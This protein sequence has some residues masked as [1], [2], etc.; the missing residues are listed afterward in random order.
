[1]TVRMIVLLLGL[2]LLIFG[3]SAHSCSQTKEQEKLRFHENH[4]FGHGVNAAIKDSG[5]PGKILG[6]AID[7]VT[8]PEQKQGWSSD[9][10]RQR[11]AAHE[12]AAQEVCDSMKKK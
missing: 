8:H 9:V 12:N 11:V 4:A 1:M 10:D 5:L 6:R 7:H 2:L 3:T